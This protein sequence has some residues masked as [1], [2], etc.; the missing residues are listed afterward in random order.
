MLVHQK[1]SAEILVNERHLLV[2]V[3]S[4]ISVF[5]EPVSMRSVG[6]VE[7][8]VNN[9]QEYYCDP[10]QVKGNYHTEDELLL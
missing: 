1:A 4:A 10:S 7:K 5:P 3:S 9:S 8:K 6:V 2:F